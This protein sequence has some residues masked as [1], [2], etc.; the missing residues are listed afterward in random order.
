[1]GDRY[2]LYCRVAVVCL[3]PCGEKYRAAFLSK[4]LAE[5]LSHATNAC[6]L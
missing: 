4:S 3:A 5:V 6:L 1:M 2:L